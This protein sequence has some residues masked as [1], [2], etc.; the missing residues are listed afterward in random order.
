MTRPDFTM[1]WLCTFKKGRETEA[2]VF[3]TDDFETIIKE[4]ERMKSESK[5]P[6]IFIDH[7]ILA[8]GK[9]L[10]DDDMIA[11]SDMIAMSSLFRI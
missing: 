2:I 9:L 1:A 7:K 11:V 8:K 3:L 5:E 10:I 4:W 6:V